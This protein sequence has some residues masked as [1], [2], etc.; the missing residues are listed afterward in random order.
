MSEKQAAVGVLKRDDGR[1]LCVWN[2]RY[3]GWSFPGGLVERKDLSPADAM[4]REFIEETSVRPTSYQ[5]VFQGPHKT[6]LDQADDVLKVVIGD[7]PDLVRKRGSIVFVFEVLGHV[8]TP[9]ES[10]LGCPIT[11]LTKEEFLKWTPFKAFYE[12]MFQDGTL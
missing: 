7:Q 9:V 1:F 12:P 4:I 3:G 6:K 2:K 5:L 10:E 8:G 11:W